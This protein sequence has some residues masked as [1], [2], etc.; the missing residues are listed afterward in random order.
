MSINT[1]SSGADFGVIKEAP[2]PLRTG[3]APVTRQTTKQPEG[4]RRASDT[5]LTTIAEQHRGGAE[6]G[7]RRASKGFNPL[8]FLQ[9][10]RLSPL[11]S[12]TGA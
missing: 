5:Q 9:N 8:R 1:T 6:M 10:N 7:T 12:K 2:K 3:S 4:F 11:P